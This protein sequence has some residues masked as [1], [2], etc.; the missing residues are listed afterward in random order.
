MIEKGKKEKPNENRRQPGG[1][2]VTEGNGKSNDHWWGL[3][4]VQQ[5]TWVSGSPSP[6]SA[7]SGTHVRSVR[8]LRAAECRISFSAATVRP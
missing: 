3:H 1:Q 5:E 7:G 2:R 6:L 4:V 8:V